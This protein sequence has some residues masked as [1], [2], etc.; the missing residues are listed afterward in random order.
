MQRSLTGD[1]GE[2]PQP[3]RTAARRQKSRNQ[4]RRHEK[5]RCYRASVSAQ[6]IRGQSVL[7]REAAALCPSFWMVGLREASSRREAL[8]LVEVNPRRVVVVAP[9]HKLLA[10]V[11]IQ[12][13]RR[14]WRALECRLPL[15]NRRCSLSEGCQS[16]GKMIRYNSYNHF[17][18]VC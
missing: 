9:R 15:K 16:D 13:N 4:G 1:C 11:P 12:R 3:H 14:H 10:A 5:S 18:D 8:D 2:N 17:S 7:E 6:E